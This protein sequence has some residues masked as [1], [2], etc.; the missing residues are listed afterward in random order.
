M[1]ISGIMS[2][3][4]RGC[5]AAARFSGRRKFRPSRLRKLAQNEIS[6]V[7]RLPD[8]RGND[9]FECLDQTGIRVRHF[10]LDPVMQFW[11]GV[12]WDHGE[13]MMFDVVIHVEVKKSEY[14]IHV[15]SARIQT[16]IAHIFRQAGMLGERKYLMQ[17]ASVKPSQRKIKQRQPALTQD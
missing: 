6:S 17:P 4:R 11:Q 10:A 2:P 13:K 7:F 9:F 16:V 12:K 14:R 15:H 3:P 1:V 8:Q 5:Y